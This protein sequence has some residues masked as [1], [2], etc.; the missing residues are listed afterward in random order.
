[1]SLHDNNLEI[2]P[3]SQS[4]LAPGSQSTDYSETTEMIQ[5]GSASDSSQN[6]SKKCDQPESPRPLTQKADDSEKAKSTPPSE[7]TPLKDNT[8][9]DR[10]HHNS[11]PGTPRKDK[12]KLKIISKSPT[13][14]LA[15]NTSLT[16]FLSPKNVFSSGSHHHRNLTSTAL[17]ARA[18]ATTGEESYLTFLASSPSTAANSPLKPFGYAASPNTIR[19]SP[20]YRVKHRESDSD[21]LVIPGIPSFRFPPL[22]LHVESSNNP[23]Y[24]DSAPTSDPVEIDSKGSASLPADLAPPAQVDDKPSRFKSTTRT[25]AVTT[26]DKRVNSDEQESKYSGSSPLRRLQRC[27]SSRNDDKDRE[28][29]FD[30]DHFLDLKDSETPTPNPPSSPQKIPPSC[31]FAKEFGLLSQEEVDRITGS[32]RPGSCEDWRNP[33]RR[34]IESPL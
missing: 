13:T 26:S 19:F 33:K 17:R 2:V 24:D 18:L 4:E 32:I 16:P 11:A 1:M 25:S 34:R 22:D 3:S 23:T 6:E 5:D 7:R 29:D 30:V 9:A 21:D 27:R 10:S 12:T 8:F 28:E 31:G 15:Q 14:R 20:F